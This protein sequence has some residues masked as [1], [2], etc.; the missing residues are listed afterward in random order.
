MFCLRHSQYVVGRVLLGTRAVGGRLAVV[1]ATS[2]GPVVGD[3]VGWRVCVRYR[4]S[5]GVVRRVG[6]GSPCTGGHPSLEAAEVRW[7]RDR[8]GLGRALRSVGA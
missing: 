8:G 6:E 5:R 2:F 1:L 7:A 3:G 4:D